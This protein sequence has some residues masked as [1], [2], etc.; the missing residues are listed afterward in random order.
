MST[1]IATDTAPPTPNA[2]TLPATTG[3]GVNTVGVLRS[4]WVKLR[5]VRS[6]VTT[7]AATALVFL[8]IGL[9]FAASIGGLLSA[10]DPE[11]PFANNP[12]G[13]TLQGTLLA[14]LIIGVLGVLVMTSEYATGTIRTSLGIVPARLPVLWAKAAVVAAVTFPVMLVTSLVT[15][16]AGQAL[17]GIGGIATAGLGDPGVLGA[18]IGTSAYLTGIAVLGLAIGTLLRGTAAAI[19]TLVGLVFLLPGLGAL[20]LP[21]SWQANV[22]QYLP[23]NAASSFTDVVPAAGQLSTTAGIAVFA[24]WVLVP[25]ALAAV[26]LKRRSA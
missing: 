4:E 13:A 19:S 11:N 8:A 22:L 2:P 9:T 14:Q 6:S 5:S 15:L 16:Y 7:L 23:G 26:A 21:A 12:A 25:L 24:A 20:L 10:S 1:V 3:R 17:I 18:V